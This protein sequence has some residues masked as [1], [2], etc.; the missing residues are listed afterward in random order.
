[1]IHAIE[2]GQ[3]EGRKPIQWKLI[4]NLPVK[5]KADAIE[6]LDW[7]ALRWKIETFH[8][9]LKSGCRAEDSKLRNA[10]LL[11]NLIA[12]IVSSHGKCYG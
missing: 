1:V 7:Y 2:R 5:C 12:M 4:T 10:E 11:A 3:P 9:V 8:K 6:K